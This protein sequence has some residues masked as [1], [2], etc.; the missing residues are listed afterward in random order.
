MC[1][2]S[3]VA[4]ESPRAFP[5]QSF[6]FC[7]NAAR[8][9]ETE[10]LYNLESAPR[11]VRRHGY[12]EQG[13][14]ARMFPSLVVQTQGLGSSHEALS[15]VAPQASIVESLGDRETRLAASKA[16]APGSSATEFSNFKLQSESKLMPSGM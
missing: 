3:W 12:S 7:P 4:A 13:R 16:I 2:A 11:N 8:S 10:R 6:T 15:T 9:T 14:N 5:L 1:L